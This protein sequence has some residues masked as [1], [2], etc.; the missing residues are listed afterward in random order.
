MDKLLLE[1]PSENS[2]I[3]SHKYRRI[4]KKIF[5]QQRK[6]ASTSSLSLQASPENKHNASTKSL[7]KLLPS[8][9]NISFIKRWIIT[10]QICPFS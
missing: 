3:T 1:I 5:K 6:E 4:N 2:E 7:S 10:A 9:E 8:G